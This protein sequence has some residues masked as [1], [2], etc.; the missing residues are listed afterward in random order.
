MNYALLP[1]LINGL[2]QMVASIFVW[3][4]VSKLHRDKLVRGVSCMM[5]AYFAAWGLWNL[6]YYPHLGQWISFWGGLT[7]VTADSVW[8]AMI[9]YYLRKERNEQ[10]P[11]DKWLDRYMDSG[12]AAAEDAERLSQL[13]EEYARTFPTIEGSSAFSEAD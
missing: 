13:S 8:F 10:R 5:V 2:L 1:D 9:L 6:F 3:V 4:S 11:V 7:L 12:N